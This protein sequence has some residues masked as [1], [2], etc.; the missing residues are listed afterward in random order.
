MQGFYQLRE[1]FAEVIKLIDFIKGKEWG[2][3]ALQSN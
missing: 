1:F 2:L 3:V